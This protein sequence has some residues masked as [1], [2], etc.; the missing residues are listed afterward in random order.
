MNMSKLFLLVGP[1][2]VGKSTTARALAARFPKS[3]HIPVDT[4]RDMVVSGVVHPSR[5][6]S[7]TLTEQLQL[8]RASAVH[9]AM[10]Y[11]KAGFTVIVDDFWDPHSGLQEYAPLHELPNFT[12]II[13][14]PVQATAEA[15]NRKRSGDSVVTSY[16]A[17]GIQL[18]YQSLQSVVATLAGQGWKVLDTTDLS[19]E[20]TAEVV[21]GFSKV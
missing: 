18:T 5:E 17:E 11:D 10:R 16:I 21:Y 12:K 3:L 13:L 7:D 19:V 20:E 9:M 4:L 1:P 14:Y 15:R 8:A 6:W 2:A